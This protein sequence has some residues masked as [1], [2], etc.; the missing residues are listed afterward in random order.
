MLYKYEYQDKV[1][2]PIFKE[3]ICFTDV[4]VP[5]VSKEFLCHMQNIPRL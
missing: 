4:Q 5:I 2:F 1:E 3:N